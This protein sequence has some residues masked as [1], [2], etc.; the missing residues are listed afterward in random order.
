[1]RK[2]QRGFIVAFIGFMTTSGV[3]IFGKHS[4]IEN[5]KGYRQLFPPEFK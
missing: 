1:M 2:Y 3:K 4:K 5:E